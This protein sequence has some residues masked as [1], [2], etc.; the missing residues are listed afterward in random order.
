MTVQ[1]CDFGAIDGKPVF[2]LFGLISPTVRV[3]LHVLSRLA[4]GLQDPGFKAAVIRKAPAAE[5]LNEA[6]RVEAAI[7]RPAVGT[8]PK[9]QQ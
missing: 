4:Y 1:I 8:S 2:A 6:R 7:Q 3:H 5:I 9:Q